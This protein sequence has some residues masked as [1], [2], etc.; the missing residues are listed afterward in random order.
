VLAGVP[1]LAT[2]CMRLTGA[3]LLWVAAA[4]AAHAE[5]PGLRLPRNVEPLAYDARIE[6]DP[7]RESFGGSID[8]TVRVLEPTDLVWLNAKKLIVTAARASVAGAAADE[9]IATVVAGSD[10]VI[11]L[12]MP[13]VLP[14]GEVKLSLAYAGRIDS[15][16]GVGLFR[17]QEAGR[18]YAVTQFEPMDARRVFPCFDEPDRK[19]PWKLTLVVPAGLRAFSNMP[20][21]GER[22][23]ATGSREVVFQRSP[24]LSSYLVAFAVGDFD[25]LDAGR[26]GRNA[27]PVKIVAPKGRAAEGAFI[28]REVGA[29]I[30]AQER[31]FGMP[32]PFPKLDLLAYPRATFGGAMENPGLITYDTRNLLARPDE[33]SPGTQMRIVGITAHEL[34]HM[35]FG[36]YVTMAWWDDVWLN[37]AFASWMGTATVAEVH[38]EWPNGAWRAR[39]RTWAMKADRLASARSIRQPIAD[40]NDVRAAFDSITYAKGETVIGMFERWQ[41]REKFRDGVRR[42]LAAHAWGNATADDFF[43]ALG[44]ADEALVPAFRGFVERA[45]VPLLDVA[46]DCTGKPTLKLAQQRLLPPGAPPEPD[47]RWTFPACF[48]YG[49]GKT[50]ATACTLMRDAR[51]TL[52]LP[53]ASCPQWVIANRD[54]IGYFLPRLSAPLSAAL[55][56]AW[57]ALAPSE[58]A[59]MLGDVLLLATSGGIGFQDALPVAASQAANPDARVA[60]RAVE[61][62]GAVPDGMLDA[63]D[64]ER[65]AA[66]VRHRYGDRARL[67]GWLPGRNEGAEAMRLREGLVPF[68]ADRGGDAA[69]ARKATQLAHR[70]VE[71]RSALTPAAR[72]P[73][74]VAAARTPGPEGKALFE[75]LAAI[76]RDGKDANEREDAIAALGSFR[77]P[78]LRDRAFALLLDPRVPTREMSALLEHALEDPQNRAHALAWLSGNIDG[79]LARVPREQHS[80]WIVAASGACTADERAQV[81]ALFASRSAAMEAGPRRYRQ[82]LERIDVCL[83]LRQAQQA[84]FA[85]F[86]AT[87]R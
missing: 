4:L 60:L 31:Y 57:R 22:A 40:A 86:L 20:V 48:A 3:L 58:V 67:V 70:W 80:G 21:E 85:A 45:G 49:D 10:D 74:L 15:R 78:A 61:I 56:A 55:P 73:V 26:A 79:L 23:T 87:A 59:E 50:S 11:G 54:G 71:H 37:E 66:Y 43:A 24:P 8:I 25:V 12:S 63:T 72:R 82:S 14:A 7:A 18:Y 47:L 38:P 69:L 53:V 42:Y 81:V 39:Q 52:V 6:L 16:G 65:Y 46:L 28:A 13:K 30:A 17:Q 41:G 44:T 1:D 84:S 33:L 68:V 77:D 62:A 76:A 34:A 19:A 35:W 9:M 5:V 75:A 29:L 27:T 32:Y 2:R 64:R 51:Q 36:D 83:A